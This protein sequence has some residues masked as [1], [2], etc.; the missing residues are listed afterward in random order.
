MRFWPIVVYI[1]CEAILFVQLWMWNE[2]A[3]AQ[4]L[5]LSQVPVL[6]LLKPFIFRRETNIQPSSSLHSKIV[7]VI[8][9]LLLLAPF[10][11][12]V[13]ASR[14]APSMLLAGHGLFTSGREGLL[15]LGFCLATVFIMAVLI[16]RR[17]T[18]RWK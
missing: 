13:E 12:M 9:T 3:F 2:I 17:G 18:P 14:H 15:V 7:L 4:L 1:L 10:V 16:Q 11:V 6:L 5:A 8:L